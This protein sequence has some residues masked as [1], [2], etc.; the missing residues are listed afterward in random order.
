MVT[1]LIILDGASEPAGARPTSLERAR[2]PEL[3]RLCCEGRLSLLLTVAPGLKPGSETAI[4]ALL[5]WAPPGPV[6]RGALEAAALGISLADG[7]RA[8]RVDGHDALERLRDALAHHTVRP[9]RGHRMLVTGSPPLPALGPGLRAW[10]EGLVPPRVLDE[11]TVVVAAPGAAAGIGRLMGALVVCPPG[12]TG[13]PDSD[14][15]AKAA[16]ALEAIDAGAE[17]VVVHVGGADEAAHARDAE[18]KVA[19]LERADTELI[20]PLATAVD[21]LRVCPDHGCDPADG[22]HCADA[23][24]VLDWPAAPPTGGRLTE[25]AAA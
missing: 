6:D 16:A 5:G 15:G 2:T 8:W 3:D 25:A 23:V 21:R 17:H 4:P 18:L 13:G 12:A 7:E 20:G 14:L 24:P 10:P 22:T 9:L 1:A 19:V 11:R